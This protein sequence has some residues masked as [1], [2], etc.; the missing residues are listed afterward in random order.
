[1]VSKMRSR[2]EYKTFFLSKYV[3][4]VSLELSV[5]FHDENAMWKRY[6]NVWNRNGCFLESVLLAFTN[7]C[8]DLMFYR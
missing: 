4:S 1:M 3:N 8:M 6:L 7:A 5:E 2:T